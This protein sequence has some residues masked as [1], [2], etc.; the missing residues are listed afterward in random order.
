MSATSE[1]VGLASA[2]LQSSQ[3]EKAL[4]LLAPHAEAK[5]ND[6]SYLQAFGET[7]LEN[8]QVETAYQ[9]LTHG[10]DLDPNASKGVEKFL[11][12]GQIIGGQ[13]GINYIDVGL[14]RFEEQLNIVT[15]NDESVEADE[16]L[17]EL[18][19]I[20]TTK[21]AIAKYLIKKLN[22]GIFA[23]IEIWMTDLCMEPEAESRCD[24][25][26]TKSLAIDDKNAESWSLLASI[27]ISQ[28]RPEDAKEALAKSWELFNEKKTDL[29]EAAQQQT[30]NA[31]ADNFDVGLEYVELLQPLLTLSKLAIESELYEIAIQAASSSQDI[32]ESLLDAYYYEGL[33]NLLEAKRLYCVKEGKKKDYRDI[34]LPKTVGDSEIQAFIDDSRIAL[35]NGYKI[36]QVDDS[37]VDE[38]V[39]EQVNELLKEVG[40]VLM[41]ELM[42]K[43]AGDDEDN[44]WEDEIYSE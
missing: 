37:E 21:D 5:Q 16:I 19:K 28:Q 24:G 13:D 44:G 36:S 8:N 31:D 22:Q 3:A 6:V 4:E 41:S 23:E 38:E 1:L 42:P 14:R 17:V 7:L 39:V 26:I 29:E 27:R 32:D 30:T 40:G 20:Y 35:T 9:V 43:R 11:Y 33:A 25:L 12:L 18:G 2:L 15:S 10:C 34:K